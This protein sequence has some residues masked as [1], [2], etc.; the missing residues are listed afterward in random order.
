MR[1]MIISQIDHEVKRLE[2]ESSK[3]RNYLSTC[4]NKQAICFLTDDEV[5]GFLNYLKSVQIG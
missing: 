5:T 3:V 4:Y 1:K 2:W